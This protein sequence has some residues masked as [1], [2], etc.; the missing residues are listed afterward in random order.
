[1]LEMWMQ[2]LWNSNEA[3]QAQAIIQ[4]DGGLVNLRENVMDIFGERI[5]VDSAD[6]ESALSSLVKDI[7]LW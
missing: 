1:M 6:L 3:G 2:S 7:I 5:A 4:K